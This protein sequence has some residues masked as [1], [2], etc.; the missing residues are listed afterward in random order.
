MKKQLPKETAAPSEK[1]IPSEID[2]GRIE[3]QD[4]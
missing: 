3:Q 1:A 4:L 2:R